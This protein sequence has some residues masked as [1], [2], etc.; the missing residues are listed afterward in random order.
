MVWIVVSQ[1]RRRQLVDDAERSRADAPARAAAIALVVFYNLVG[2]LDV[3][4]TTRAIGL[5]VA[6]EVN[7]ILRALMDGFGH[8]W[9]I[10]KLLLQALITVMV[11]W[12][13]HRFVLTLFALAVTFNAIVVANNFSIA[14]AG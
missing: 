14:L 5:G 2:V 6:E 1:K 10:G 12:F 13:P 4:S 9:I 8:G 3:V 11:L 7:P